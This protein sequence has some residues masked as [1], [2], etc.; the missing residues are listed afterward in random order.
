MRMGYSNTSTRCQMPGV[1]ITRNGM[2]D[3]WVRLGVNYEYLW[4][5]FWVLL[6]EKPHITTAEL[7]WIGPPF[8]VVWTYWLT[9]PWLRVMFLI[10]SFVCGCVHERDLQMYIYVV[11]FMYHFGCFNVE[12]IHNMNG[13]FYFDFWRWIFQRMNG[14]LYTQPFL[15]AYKYT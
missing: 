4:W 6:L 12:S 3:L 11:V 13:I 15:P 8:E 10:L 9:Q 14:M 5:V 7:T 1:Q 2:S